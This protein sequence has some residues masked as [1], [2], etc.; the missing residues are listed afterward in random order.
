MKSR[1][2]STMSQRSGDAI[3]LRGPIGGHF[4]W[5]IEDGGPILLLGGGSGVVPLVSM[6][7]HRAGEDRRSPMA[8]LYSART[9][10]E[11]IYRDE[12]E[13][14]VGRGEGFHLAFTLTRDDSSRAGHYSRRIDRPMVSDLLAA[15][16][17]ATAADIRLRLKPLRRSG[18]ARRDR[19]RPCPH[20]HPHR[21]LR[22]LTF[23]A[24]GATSPLPAGRTA[25]SLKRGGK[26]GLHGRTVPGNA[27]RGQPQGKCHRDRTAGLRAGKGEKVG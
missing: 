25:A 26:S 2:S 3:E 15:A 11:L 7:R 20:R 12:L 5:S 6:L 9:W 27:R 14:L 18:D 24:T 23:P 19:S 16:A 4:V 1:P 17:G 8:L 21:T 13:S 22:R 10:D